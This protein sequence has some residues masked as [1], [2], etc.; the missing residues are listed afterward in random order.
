[1]IPWKGKRITVRL[2]P[3]SFE[4]NTLHEPGR[5]SPSDEVASDI[6][7]M[8]QMLWDLEHEADWVTTDE[9]DKEDCGSDVKSS[10]GC[11]SSFNPDLFK[12]AKFF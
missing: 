10:K 8:R 9:E 7:E 11:S 3:Q 2:P 4:G 12:G 1:M 6:E 5:M